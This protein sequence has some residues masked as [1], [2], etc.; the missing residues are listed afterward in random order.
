MSIFF[1]TPPL[2]TPGFFI[3]DVTPAG[4]FYHGMDGGSFCVLCPWF[5]VEGD[6]RSCHQHPNAQ[7]TIRPYCIYAEPPDRV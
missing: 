3:A 1:L 7:R 5:F 6:D 2:G 4:Y